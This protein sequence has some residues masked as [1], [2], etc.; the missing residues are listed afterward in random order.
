MD[1]QWTSKDPDVDQERT[2]SGEDHDGAEGRAGASPKDT[3]Y[4]EVVE[5]VLIDRK[6]LSTSLSKRDKH[7]EQ[8]VSRKK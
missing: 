3:R 2:R 8:S 5:T 1:Q 4:K 6:C 7:A